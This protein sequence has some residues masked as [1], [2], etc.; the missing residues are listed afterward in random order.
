MCSD[1]GCCRGTGRRVCESYGSEG[2]QQRPRNMSGSKWKDS[3]WDSTVLPEYEN[4]D[5][6]DKGEEGREPSP[7][8]CGSTAERGTS[9]GLPGVDGIARRET[10]QMGPTL[11]VQGQPAVGYTRVSGGHRPYPGSLGAYGGW[12]K[13][14]ATEAAANQQR[15]SGPEAAP[16]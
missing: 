2:S 4:L 15:W 6:T 7:R 5:Q 12:G 10:W 3:R 9:V 16:L 13:G 8:Q 11:G 1:R 14:R